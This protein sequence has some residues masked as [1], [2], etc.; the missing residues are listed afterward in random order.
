MRKKIKTFR[1]AVE[2]AKAAMNGG[3]LP[4]KPCVFIIC[5]CYIL[6]SFV[7]RI[8]HIFMYMKVVGLHFYMPQRNWINYDFHTK[9]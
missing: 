7:N 5:V 2:A 3:I 8:F 9:M 4:G 6:L 1:N